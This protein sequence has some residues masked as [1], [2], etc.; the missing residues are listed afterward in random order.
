MNVFL[1]DFY[2]RLRAWHTLKLELAEKDLE[3]ICLEVD[4]FWQFCPMST[5]YLHP[6]DV[7]TWPS[8]WELLN[9]NTFCP[10]S[11]ALGMMYTLVLLGIKEVDIVEATDYNNNEVVLVLVDR[12]KYIMNYWPDTVVNNSLADFKIKNK[13]N[14][15]ILIRK[16]GKA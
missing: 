14:T 6:E 1:L 12:A 15:D 3:H 9:D 16:I 5:H 2:V 13:I 11:R 10:Y 4:K 8:P 7:E